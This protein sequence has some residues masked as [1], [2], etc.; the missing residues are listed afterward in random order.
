MEP[1]E[2]GEPMSTNCGRLLRVNLSTGAGVWEPIPS[3]HHQRFI[4][5]RGLGI[6]YLYEELG[7]QTDP[8]GPENKL[9]LLSG[10]LGG[11]K[12]MG[13]GRW[14]AMTRSPQT[15]GLARSVGGG[16][17]AA[18]LK[19]AGC[20][21]L[22]LEGKAPQPSHLLIDGDGPRLLPADHIWGL[23][24]QE[25]QRVLKD[26]HGKRT[27][28]GC[29]G[30]AGEKL[31]RYAVIAHGTRTA[32]RCG[33]GTVMGSKNLKA[34]SINV[35][36]KPL[37]PARP[38]R[39]A[40][41][42][43]QHASI[44]KDH[45]RRVKMHTFGTTF[46]AEMTRL[47]GIL[48]VKNFQMGDMEDIEGIFTDAYA[49]MRVGTHGCYNCMTRCGQIHEVTDGPYRGS[50][51][52]GPEYETIWAFGSQVGNTDAAVTVAAD[53]L[54]DVLG[55]DTISTGNTIG[56]AME[57]FQRGILTTADTGGMELRWG[58]GQA[59]MDLIRK[60]ANREG[61]G[62][63]LA[64]GVK[65]AAE[66]IGKGADRYAI[67]CKGLELPAYEPR[68]AKI[69]GLS[70]ATSNI[71]GSHM[72]G[73]ARQEI[74]GKH[75]PRP[76]D[77]FADSGNGDIA[78]LNQIGKA[79]EETG[80]L[81]NFADSGMTQD[82]LANMYAAGTGFEECADVE[83]LHLVGERIVTLER[84]FNIRF[85]FSRKDDALPHRMVTEPLENAG[86]AT[87]QVVRN[88]D[89][90]LDE[91]YQA[92]GYDGDGKPTAKRLQTLGIDDIVSHETK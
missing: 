15:F 64:E 7:A 47:M 77:R 22:I 53:N 49:A 5:G 31:V 87:G 70:M 78:A 62:E 61:I 72:Y 60:I 63:I 17:L 57:L 33:V 18:F 23:D 35:P 82:L 59:L 48:P 36:A 51:S 91:Y 86:A 9:L 39:F 28:T 66:I 14:I 79:L 81:C 90:L 26:T 19:F 11:T 1:A 10:A 76:V 58:D 55:L 83:Y 3:D 29:I 74:A 12:A 43:Q 25:T 2:Q 80:I 52:E 56:F 50:W 75:D 85:G 8:L 84:C 71:G 6:R 20:D 30:P 16:N 68:A 54:C 27:Q 89:A 92:L 65:R 42:L 38:E 46:L 67:H 24:T 41:L 32:S 13:F 45:K 69:H 44:L 34:V 73:Y 88:L 4:G 37:Q 40:A 21:L